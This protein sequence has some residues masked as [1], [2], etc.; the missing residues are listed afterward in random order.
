MA[1]IDDLVRRAVQTVQSI[2][3]RAVSLA[4][5]V[6]LVVAIVSM[7]GFALGVAALSDGVEQVWVVLGIV[8]GSI[9][10]GS[11]ILARWRFGTVRRHVPELADE[12]RTLVA[13][14]PEHG[15]TV[16]ETFVVDDEA[17][18][19][20]DGSAVVMTR[21]MGRF[22]AGLGPGIGQSV[23]L[24]AAVKALTTFPLLMFAAITITIVFGFLSFIFLIA[25]AL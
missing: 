17:G 13:E 5:K 11:A 3:D 22:Q 14:N 12:V 9:A 25:L 7:G 1:D 10:I 24:A 8:F 2:A 4:T 19:P 18:Q 23:R 20:A 15:R 21:Q 6:L 16:I